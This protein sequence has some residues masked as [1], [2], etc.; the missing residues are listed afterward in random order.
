MLDSIPGKVFVVGVL[1]LISCIAYSSQIVIFLPAYGWWTMESLILLTP[2]NLL[3]AM[4]FYNYYLAVTTDP[5]KIPIGWVNN[6]KRTRLP[7]R[8]TLSCVL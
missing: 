3:V 1:L 7:W 6:D 8:L 4:V 2:L 5:G